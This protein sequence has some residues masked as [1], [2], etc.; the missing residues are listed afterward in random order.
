MIIYT[1]TNSDRALG[2]FV[3][4]ND[5]TGS[6]DRGNYAVS[7]KPVGNGR[8]REARVEGFSRTQSGAWELLRQALNALHEAGDLP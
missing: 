8:L 4:V 7:L 6:P 2:T 5:G 3:I 1:G